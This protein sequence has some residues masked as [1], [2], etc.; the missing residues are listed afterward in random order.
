MTYGNRLIEITADYLNLARHVCG[1]SVVCAHAATVATLR[2]TTP[3]FL[4]PS[5]LSHVM[6]AALMQQTRWLKPSNACVV[7]GEPSGAARGGLW[8]RCTEGTAASQ[9][10]HEQPTRHAPEQ[11]RHSASGDSGGGTRHNAEGVSI[12]EAKRRNSKPKDKDACEMPPESRQPSM[13]AKA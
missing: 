11:P 5:L 3:S 4:T 10:A 1:C 6:P 13:N 7:R 8:P 9:Q 2:V 12:A